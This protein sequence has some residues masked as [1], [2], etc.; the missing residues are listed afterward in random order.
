[1]FKGLGAD[2]GEEKEHGLG[3]KSSCG[4]RTCSELDSSLASD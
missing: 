4:V 2:R 3:Q 1:M